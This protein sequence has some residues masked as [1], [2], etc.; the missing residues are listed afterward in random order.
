MRHPSL[1]YSG[2]L[3]VCWTAAE[4]I[5][6]PGSFLPSEAYMHARQGHCHKRACALAEAVRS[7]A[8]SSA[9]RLWL[10]ASRSRASAASRLATSSCLH[11][12]GGSTRMLRSILGTNA[13]RLTRSWSCGGP[14]DKKPCSPH[15]SAAA[16]A[17]LQAHPAS[18]LNCA[19]SAASARASACASLSALCRL[20]CSDRSVLASCGDGGA[21][22]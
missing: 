16:A 19:S 21:E 11:Q 17:A 9:L 15:P 20:R 13:A 1:R 2:A 22:G 14:A 10:A 3:P 6:Q 7:A 5:S 8:S 18:C 4:G 12:T